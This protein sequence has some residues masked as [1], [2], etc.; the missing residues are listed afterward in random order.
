[1]DKDSYRKAS[2]SMMYTGY[3]LG[4]ICL[5]LEIGISRFQF[6]ES[7]EFHDFFW[8]FRWI[9]LSNL[10]NGLI[11]VFENILMKVLKISMKSNAMSSVFPLLEY[12]L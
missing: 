10:L 2:R 5:I 3:V 8:F 4:I 9:I 11:L 1:M 6:S 7:G 12:V